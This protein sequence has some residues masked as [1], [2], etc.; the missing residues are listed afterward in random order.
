MLACALGFAACADEDVEKPATDS[1]HTADATDASTDAST[2]DA[3]DDATHAPTGPIA[4][5]KEGLTLTTDEFTLDAGQE[6]YLCFATT[7]GEDAV[8]DAYSSE[9]QPFVHHIVFVRTLAPEP[10]GFAE[11]D[12]LF[13][14]TWDPLYLAGA[15]AS[16]LQFPDDAGHKLTKGTQLLA[17]LHLLNA[18]DNEVHGRVSIN[19]HRSTAS[20]PRPVSTYVFGT[21]QIELPPNQAS[22]ITSDCEMSE[23]VQLIAAFPHLH[24]LGTALHF[25]VGDSLDHMKDVYS[26]D[27]YSFDDQHTEDLD[28]KLNKGDKTRVTCSYD[29][30]TPDEVTFGESTHNEMCFFI[31]F[32]LDRT[33]ITSCGSGM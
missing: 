18:S 21:R 4:S 2:G 7:L 24:Q 33:K 29:N 12:T 5:N 22:D 9:A 32:A 14:M 31:A 10:D 11:C 16:K 1:T 19:M 28:L 25:E 17:Q 26:R 8:I 3:T 23:P 20:D 13:R 6:R 27:P 30:D 15:G